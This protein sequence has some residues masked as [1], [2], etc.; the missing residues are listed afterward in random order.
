MRPGPTAPSPSQ[1]NRTQEALM[2]RSSYLPRIAMVILLAMFAG[3]CADDGETAANG[4]ETGGATEPAAVE[5]TTAPDAQTGAATGAET[6]TGGADAE[7]LQLG[8]ILPETG[9]LAYLAPPMTQAV[10]YAIEQINE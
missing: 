7:P 4:G 10:A 2:S 5:Q 6:Q 9:G 8:T 3:A 1:T